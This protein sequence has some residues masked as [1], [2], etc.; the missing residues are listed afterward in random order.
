MN[1]ITDFM[2]LPKNL[3]GKIIPLV[4]SSFILF[5][6]DGTPGR[7]VNPSP[8]GIP[9]DLQ[10]EL[11]R[12]V[13]ENTT[14]ANNAILQSKVIYGQL[15][16][17][18]NTVSPIDLDAFI[19]ARDKLLPPMFI[20]ANALSSDAT[21]DKDKQSLTSDFKDIYYNSLTNMLRGIN[22]NL[23]IYQAFL[24][25]SQVID[26]TTPDNP[27]PNTDEG[28]ATLANIFVASEITEL[29]VARLGQFTTISPTDETTTLLNGVK[30]QQ[31]VII[32]GIINYTTQNII[33]IDQAKA[34]YLVMVQSLTNPRLLSAIANLAIVIYGKENV[35]FRQDELTASQPDP[36]MIVMV[37]REGQSTYRL[38]N[39]ENN[40]VVNRV[41]NDTRNLSASDL[42]F[43]S[44]VNVVKVQ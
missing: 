39:I 22:N 11:N 25:S 30:N 32:N 16:G 29:F 26:A 3:S 35:A 6:C 4:L 9:S 27:F 1:K 21:V 8:T 44:N 19:E 12:T 2:K 23:R 18:W 42:L 34:A 33:T 10:D 20:A 5:S 37:I 17:R 24:E 15:V 36:N 13:T 28:I 38:I 31:T 43:Q 41:S 7:A 14:S 40:R